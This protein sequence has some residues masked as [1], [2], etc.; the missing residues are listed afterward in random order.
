MK[1][2]YVI[3]NMVLLYKT[4]SALNSLIYGLA[5]MIFLTHDMMRTEH[6]PL[7]YSSKPSEWVHVYVRFFNSVHVLSVRQVHFFDHQLQVAGSYSN[8]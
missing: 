2:L 8:A 6:G 5:M 7:T 1:S 4:G 3:E